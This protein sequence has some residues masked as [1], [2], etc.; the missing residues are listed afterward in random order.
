[1]NAVRCEVV[2]WLADDPQP[3]WVEASLVDVHGRRWSF[4]DK[5]TIFGDV[6]RTSECPLPGVI[7]CEVVSS[8]RDG[9]GAEVLEVRLL[10][11]VESTDGSTRFFVSADNVM[12]WSPSAGT[13][14]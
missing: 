12:P 3:G 14:T 5:P 11:G 1:M 4:L 8:R 6:F 7:R 2:R 10:D 13:T 9:S